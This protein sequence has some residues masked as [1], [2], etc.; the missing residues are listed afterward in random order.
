MVAA[1]VVSGDDIINVWIYIY[2]MYSFLIFIE[3]WDNFY[4]Y[5][6][7]AHTHTDAETHTLCADGIWVL[8]WI[9][10]GEQY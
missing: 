8:Q 2:S 1:I 6:Y 7:C 10:L 4:V 3:L 9:F 5:Y